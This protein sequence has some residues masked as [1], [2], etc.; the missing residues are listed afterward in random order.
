MKIVTVLVAMARA[1]ATCQAAPGVDSGKSRWSGRIVQSNEG[2]CRTLS[3]IGSYAGRWAANPRA[4][5]L[6]WTSAAS[7]LGSV[8]GVWARTGRIESRLSK[9]T[10][11]IDPRFQWFGKGSRQ[12]LS[13]FVFNAKTPLAMA[14][15][16]LGRLA[17]ISRNCTKFSFDKRL[18]I[19]RRLLHFRRGFPF[20]RRRCDRFGSGKRKKS[21]YSH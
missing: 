5:G 10:F 12:A 8:C 7:N 20:L 17:R 21:A 16:A 11:F 9:A 14:R 6:T 19:S 4:V 18:L 2:A 13:S 1:T 15:P 3:H